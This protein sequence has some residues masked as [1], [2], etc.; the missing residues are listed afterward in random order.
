[1]PKGTADRKQFALIFV[2]GDTEVEFYTSMLRTYVADVPK[3]LFNLKGNY[4]APRKVL[5]KT[6][7]FLHRH[8]GCFARVYCCIDRE[9]RDHNP[10]L[11]IVD[12]RKILREDS[13]FNRLLSADAI[14]STQVIE[15][16]YFYDLEGIYKFLKVP[17]SQRNPARF[18]PPEKFTH[19]HLAKLFERYGKTY[20]KGHRS[21]NFISN[22]DLAKIYTNCNELKDGL[23]LIA[24]QASS[25][26]RT[27]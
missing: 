16:W 25:W 8:K 15:S 19:I 12:L 10:P 11:D 3:Y 9:S 6:E 2:E 7:D 14:I 26:E 22:L 13:D 21:A 5:G 20:I 27:L 18:A 23:D 24:S 1:M 17:K 4:N